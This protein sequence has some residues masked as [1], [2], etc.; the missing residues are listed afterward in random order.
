MVEHALRRIGRSQ[1]VSAGL[2]PERTSGSVDQV[3]PEKV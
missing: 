1:K 3:A 2:K